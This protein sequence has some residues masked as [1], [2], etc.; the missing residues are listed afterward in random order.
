MASFLH[1]QLSAYAAVSRLETTPWADPWVDGS[2]EG[3]WCS[4]QQLVL[5]RTWAM[6]RNREG[7]NWNWID[8]GM[9]GEGEPYM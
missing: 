5:M 6:E 9:V 7:L 4:G 1:T 2:A 3:G 8:Q